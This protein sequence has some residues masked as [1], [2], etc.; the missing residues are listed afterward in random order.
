MVYNGAVRIRWLRRLLWVAGFG[1]L[2]LNVLDDPPLR[3]GAYLQDVTT[4][5]VTVAKITAGP[6]RATCTVFEVGGA[7]VAHVEAP[8]QR[9][10]ALRVTGLRPGTE[11]AYE[12]AVD[13]GE[14]ERGRIRTAPDRDDAPVHFAFL[15]DSGDQPWW[16]WL[17]RTPA[18]HWPSAWD[19]L[20][21]KSAVTAIG[22]AVAADGPDFVL[23]LGDVIYPKGLNAHYRSGFFRPFADVI[24]N[25][26]LYPVPGNHDVM[27]AAGQQLLANFRAP[28]STATGDG[29]CYS[30]VRGPLR[31]IV[32]DC[33][34]DRTGDRYEPGHPAYDYLA[35]E[36]AAASEPWV[37]AASHYP[38]QSASRQWDR[39][40]LLLSLLPVLTEYQV[41]LYLS[42]HDHCYQRFRPQQAGGMPL[43]V[44]GG[45]GKDLYEVRPD[46]RAIKL[47]SEHH[48]CRADVLRGRMTVT[49]RSLAGV[50]IDQ[51][52]LQLP[53][54]AAL[55]QLRQ[56]NPARAERIARLQ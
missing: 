42:G 4:D 54:G 12:F 39:P 43:V 1:C 47:V 27:D 20:P 8:A 7:T 14:V 13:G 40:D 41:S 10:H 33:N 24:R 56:S 35:S 21:T 18:L 5:A 31:V 55:E 29:L 48:W 17:Q 38:M 15:G 52:E 23:H 49:A 28:K 2:W 36:L 19:W 53:G 16:V 11:Y 26:P 3:S 6:T 50:V 44:S 32:L 46:P 37:V 30:F 51:F 25:A 34:I 45:G 22:A 9:R